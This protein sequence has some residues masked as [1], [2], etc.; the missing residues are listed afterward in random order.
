MNGPSE[1]VTNAVDELVIANHVLA[2]EGVL[3]ALGHVSLRHPERSDRYLL[4]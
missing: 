2:R 1:A 3:D 4:S